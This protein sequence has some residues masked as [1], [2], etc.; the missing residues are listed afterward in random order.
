[1]KSSLKEIPNN[2]FTTLKSQIS[3][4]YANHVNLVE[5][6][7]ISFAFGENLLEVNFADNQIKRIHETIFY[8]APNLETLDLS[9]NQISEFSSDAF[10]KL[11]SLKILDLSNNLITTVPFELFQPL[12]NIVF[13][14]LRHNKIQIKFGIFPEY[15]KTLDLSFNSLDLY[16]K[17]KIFTLLKYLETLLIHGN[18]IES[19]HISIFE[20]NLK[21]LG[22]S[23]NLFSCSTLA[24]IFIAMKKRDIVSAPEQIVKNTSNIRGVKCIEWY[25][26]EGF[27]ERVCNVEANSKASIKILTLTSLKL[28]VYVFNVLLNKFDIKNRF[29]LVQV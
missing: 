17:F 7:R 6:R 15:V 1:M 24:D 16:N 4:L 25:P 26:D 29:M 14:N 21:F 18:K 20:S 23:D 5:L 28:I 2:I 10:E 9:N 3:H 13:L 8:N 19:I 22:I 11:S 12:T 27:V